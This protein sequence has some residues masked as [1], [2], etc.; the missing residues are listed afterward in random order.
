MGGDLKTTVILVVLLVI[1][2]G[3]VVVFHSGWLQKPPTTQPAEESKK[4]T[5]DVGKVVRLAV[6]KPRGGKL[7]LVRKLDEWRL[8]EP[9]D[10]PAT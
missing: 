8:A 3:Y 5:P 4:L 9:V 7:V 10:A 1:C 2:V 6:D